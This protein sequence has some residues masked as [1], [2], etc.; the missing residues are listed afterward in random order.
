ME[1]I[2]ILGA[3]FLIMLAS[4]AGIFFVQEKIKKVF[5]KNIHYFISFSAGIFLI[6]AFNLSLEA[7]EHSDDFILPS[8]FIIGGFFFSI[9]FTKILPE[10]HQ[11]HDE[12]CPHKHESKKAKKILLGDGI[13]NFGDGLI[14]ISAFL[15][16]PLIGFGTALSIFL[17]EIIQE[18]SEFFVLKE[19]GYSTKKA[20][21]TNFLVSGTIIPGG[22]L[23]YYFL[24]SPKLQGLEI[25]VLAFSAGIFFNVVI[26]DLIPSAHHKDS[27]KKNLISFI[28]ILLGIIILY[29]ITNLVSHSH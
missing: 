24:N 3:I 12:C 23:S 13:H 22:I 25:F 2:Y 10:T 6:T 18:I 21:L 28:F 8:I 26:T 5:Q 20:L 1:I 15:A 9:F 4:L 7:F 11:H 27:W 14:L 17:H 16:S 19:A 29:L